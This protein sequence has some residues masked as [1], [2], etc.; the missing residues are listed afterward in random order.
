MFAN[1]AHRRATA[2]ERLPTKEYLSGVAPGK[3]ELSSKWARYTPNDVLNPVRISSGRLDE[4]FVGG[5]RQTPGGSGHED[6]SDD[7]YPAV[8]PIRRVIEG[9]L[10]SYLDMLLGI[11]VI[12]DCLCA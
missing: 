6:N 8:A 2:T 12:V 5:C 4:L 11:S 1:G 3:V 7:Y 9:R 10:A